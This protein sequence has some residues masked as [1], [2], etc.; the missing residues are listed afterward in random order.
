[1][2]GLGFKRRQTWQ[3]HEELLFAMGMCDKYR[4]FKYI[5]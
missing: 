4:M 1:M 5:R 2:E 3:P